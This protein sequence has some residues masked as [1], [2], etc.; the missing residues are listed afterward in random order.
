ML[1]RLSDSAVGWTRARASV[2][3]GNFGWRERRAWRAGSLADARGLRAGGG[4]SIVGDVADAG[5][6]DAARRR[7]ACGRR[8]VEVAGRRRF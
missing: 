7:A 8:V 1:K 5:E 6:L 3:K 4:E 2:S